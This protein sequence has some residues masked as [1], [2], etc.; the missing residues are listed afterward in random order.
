MGMSLSCAFPEARLAGQGFCEGELVADGTACG[1]VLEDGSRRWV[2]RFSRPRTS[3]VRRFKVAVLAAMSTSM[4]A[5]KARTKM[6]AE[7]RCARRA[8]RELEK[9]V[10]MG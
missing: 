7:P 10:F 4:N 9:R 6:T 1:L 2:W 3:R 5:S 8:G